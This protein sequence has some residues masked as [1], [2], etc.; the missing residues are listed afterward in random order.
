M[1]AGKS[2]K[3]MGFIYKKIFFSCI[4]LLQNPDTPAASNLGQ[5]EWE[6]RGIQ[7]P[8]P[9]GLLLACCCQRL[10][11]FVTLVTTPVPGD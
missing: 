8:P 1:K 9:S 3:G 6:E 10:A 2:S 5:E 7:K 4:A 11:P